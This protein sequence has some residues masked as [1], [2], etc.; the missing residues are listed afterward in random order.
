MSKGQPHRLLLLV[1]VLVCAS[2]WGPPSAPPEAAPAQVDPVVE[3]APVSNAKP[4]LDSKERTPH[5]LKVGRWMGRVVERKPG[6]VRYRFEAPGASATFVDLRPRQPGDSNRYG[7][8]EVAVS[9]EPGVAADPELLDAITGWLRRSE[10][11]PSTPSHAAGED[12]GEPGHGDLDSPAVRAPLIRAIGQGLFGLWA[13]AGLIALLGAWRSRSHANPEPPEPE[14]GSWRK[15]GVA[16]LVAAG[17][18]GLRL[19]FAAPTPLDDD[20]LRDLGSGMSCAS[21]LC[22]GGA[23]ASFG[24][25]HHGTGFPRLLGLCINMGLDVGGIQVL[26]TVLFGL[27]VAVT[28]DAGRRLGILV[29]ALAAAG[30][31]SLLLAEL[32][33]SGEVLWN[34]ASVALPAALT[35]AAVLR[36]AATGRPGPFLL[37]GV[38]AGLA[39]EAHVASL[40]LWPGLMIVTAVTAGGPRAGRSTAAELGLRALWLPVLAGALAVPMIVSPASSIVNGRVILAE[41][42]WVGLGVGALN[43]I[44]L[45]VGLRRWSTASDASGWRPSPAALAL[46][47]PLATLIVI[48][49]TS[50]FVEAHPVRYYAPAFPAIAV[51]GAWLL[52]HFVTHRFEAPRAAAGVVALVGGV[53]V[54]SSLSAYM[55]RMAVDRDRWNYAD[56]RAIAAVLRERGVGGGELHLAIRGGLCGRERYGDRGQ[57]LDELL[58]GG[59][60][61]YGKIDLDPRARGRPPSTWFVAKLRNDELP[62]LT[63]P[64]TILASGTG[65]TIVMAP[66]DPVLDLAAM[67]HCVQVAGA[68]AECVT[69][70]P[71]PLDLRG[72]LVLPHHD[73]GRKPGPDQQLVAYYYEIPLHPVSTPRQTTLWISAQVEPGPWRI[74]ELEGGASTATELPARRVELRVEPGVAASVTVGHLLDGDDPWWG[75]WPPVLE[76]PEDLELRALV[77]Q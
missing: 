46:A 1:L 74:I 52:V 38:C 4:T 25:V 61:L 34:P 27:A 70:E 73:P 76:L 11:G 56:V 15:L 66:Y 35:V 6:R 18:I 64:A 57:H 10:G 12:P 59:L 54:L 48:L 7:T 14:R 72:G 29:G 3:T 26:L 77:L 68:E 51:G 30:E 45:A 58:V 47:L 23:T 5:Y 60:R 28:F 43:C 53:L 75:R 69:A 37:A 16:L 71:L 2:G 32:S 9:P 31:L 62:E 49:F 17:A 39:Y 8:D 36:G 20:A 21:G 13:V 24:G 41:L 33:A 40:A 63:G 42:G 50:G 44:I 22:P 55:G 67:R 19:I 65:H